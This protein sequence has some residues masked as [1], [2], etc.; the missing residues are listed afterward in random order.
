MRAQAGTLVRSAA[1][2]THAVP[3]TTGVYWVE[4]G[5]SRSVELTGFGSDTDVPA[6]CRDI[7]ASLVAAG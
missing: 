7:A 1:D 5:R 3:A 6:I 4:G 2:P